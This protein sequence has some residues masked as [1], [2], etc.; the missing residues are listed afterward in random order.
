MCGYVSNTLRNA[1]NAAR[2][3]RSIE[4]AKARGD[5]YSVVRQQKNGK[6]SKPFDSNLSLQRANE[7]KIDLE[8]L[9]A[10]SIFIVI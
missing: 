2:Q 3:S 1:C 4:A 9:N 8:R 7:R 10:G 6:L 5:I